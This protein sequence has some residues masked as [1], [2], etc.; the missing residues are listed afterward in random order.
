MMT[1]TVCF[2]GLTLL[3]SLLHAYEFGSSKHNGHC[4]SG[5]ECKLVASGVVNLTQT[6]SPMR[7]KNIF[8]NL[9]ENIKGVLRVYY[10]RANHKDAIKGA[11]H[12]DNLAHNT[13]F[14]LYRVIF[15]DKQGMVAQTR[16][17][18]HLSGGRNQRLPFSTIELTAEDMK[19]IHSYEIQLISSHHKIRTR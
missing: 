9:N 16:G 1:R 4:S 19:N 10:S 14:I 17:D 12:I 18:I 7:A 11:F 15:R 3:S 8:F 6:N 2:L 13:S 5:T